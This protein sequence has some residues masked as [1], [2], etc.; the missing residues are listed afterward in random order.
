MCHKTTLFFTVCA[1]SLKLPTIKCP[2]R[3]SWKSKL[4]MD[5]CIVT[6][7]AELIRGWCAECE[8]V[9]RGDGI[10]SAVV[11]DFEPR[12]AAFISQYWAFKS[13]AGW[14]GPMDAT[15]FPRDLVERKDEIDCKTING[16]RYEMYALR[17]ATE[18]YGAQRICIEKL[19]CVAPGP[20]DFLAIIE[21]AL[22][23]TIEWGM[24]GGKDEPEYPWVSHFFAPKEKVP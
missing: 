19:G 4:T 23:L 12:S 5:R 9:F 18:A 17:G 10:N 2:K 6:K 21:K 24:L 11:R 16:A 13:Q 20:A 15:L 1:H 14:V 22:R 7:E 3:L 8:A